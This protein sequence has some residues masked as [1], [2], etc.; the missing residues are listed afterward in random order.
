MSYV[1]ELYDPFEQSEVAVAGHDVPLEA[2][3]TTPL[4]YFL[5]NPSFRRLDTYGLLWPDRIRKV[6]GL[7]MVHPYE[8]GKIPVV[9]I[10]GLWSSPMTWMEAFNDLQSY[11]DIR[12]HY[13]FWFYLYPSGQP[14]PETAAALH[15]EIER[16]RT[17]FGSG[18]PAPE[19]NQMVLVGHSMG[20]LIARSLSI[21]GPEAADCVTRVVTIASPFRGSDRSNNLTRWLARH[22]IRLPRTT[23]DATRKFMRPGRS[24]AEAEELEGLTSIDS[25][26]PE[27]P[28][29]QALLERPPLKTVTY[30]NIIGTTSDGPRES[31]TDGVV[32]YAS[33][34][35]DGVESELMV[36][37]DHLHV[38]QHPRTILELK[39]ILER[40]LESLEVKT[41][42]TIELLEG[43]AAS[44]H[45]S[46]GG[47]PPKE[48]PQ[49]ETA[50]KRPAASRS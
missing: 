22:M 35:T 6:S 14:F 47:K 21:D 43:R 46:G 13:Q 32:T 44:S 48:S 50:G 18:R 10:H 34:H 23:M 2:D 39:R 5:S 36:Q 26:S 29:L 33:A 4:A 30:N 1:L 42:P 28:I 20:G 40:H 41:K 7:Y 37:A 27:S 19:L 3:I 24:D 25:L 9:M 38:H 49:A 12:D 15:K 45:G 8:P 31:A 11:A 16:V 17:F